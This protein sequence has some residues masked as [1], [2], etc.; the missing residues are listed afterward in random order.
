MDG[1]LHLTSGTITNI[2]SGPALQLNTAPPGWNITATFRSRL[3]SP[4][5][6][7]GKSYVP[8][9]YKVV[10]QSEYYMLVRE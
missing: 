6:V 5:E 4:V 8:S 2:G 10:Q 1:T 9:G 7:N 3:A